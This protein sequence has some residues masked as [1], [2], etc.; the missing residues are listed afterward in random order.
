[1]ILLA[2]GLVMFGVFAA[3][4]HTDR[5]RLG[6]GVFLL[7]GALFAGVSLV[8]AAGD[9]M[10]RLLAVVVIVLSP[11]AVLTL[12]GLLV[13]NGVQMVAR[14]GL[15]LPN[16]LSL[17]AGLVLLFP[18]VLFVTAVVAESIWI[19]VGAASLTLVI[20]YFGLSL[21][22]FLVYAFLYG[23][24]GYQPGMDAIVVHGAGLD[25]GRVPPLLASRLDRALA[26][27]RAEFDSGR[28]PVVVTSGGKGP[29]EEVSEALAMS[30][31]LVE[32]GLPPE[33]V[34]HEDRSTNTNENLL[35][36]AE[37]LG[38]RGGSTRMVL[39]TSNFHI[40]RTA[41]LARRLELDAEVVGAR[42]AYYYLPS[43]VLR[44][45]VGL[46]V[47]YK[48]MNTTACLA[49]LALPPLVV[50]TVGVPWVSAH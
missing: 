4:F 26:V 36:T 11:V 44:E 35:F 13:G 37:L 39:V 5:R 41:I 15:R 34:V 9:G 38:D 3:R 20:G 12:A 19:A 45:F 31:Y 49:L 30:T 1:M 46:I 17:G 28:S 40:L 33:K 8:T 29:D 10:L 16:V 22:A 2:I 32:N 24:L 14:E 43:A 48:W 25:G 47:E 42:T 21:I 6:N 27:F 23:R 7:L 50:L 18:Y